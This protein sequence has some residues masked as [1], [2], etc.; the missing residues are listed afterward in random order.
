MQDFWGAGLYLECS[1]AQIDAP[2]NASKISYLAKH[3]IRLRSMPFF[4]SHQIV[5]HACALLQYRLHTIPCSVHGW[6]H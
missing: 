5:P 4:L 3:S 6:S 2:F 1:A